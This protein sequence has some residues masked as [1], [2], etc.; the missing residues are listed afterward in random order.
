MAIETPVGFRLG[1]SE[2]YGRT[3]SER[4]N[5]LSKIY[6]T[7]YQRYGIGLAGSWKAFGGTTDV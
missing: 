3:L 2:P 4:Y 5:W 7:N 1:L 6:I